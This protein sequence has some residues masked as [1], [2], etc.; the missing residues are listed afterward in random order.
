MASVLDVAD[1]GLREQKKQRTR[2]DLVAVA[3]ELFE[4]R[5]FDAVTVEEIAAAAMVS[6]RTFF[7]YFGSKEAVLFSDHDEML[8][9]LREAIRSQPADAPPLAVL[10]NAAHQ[11]ARYSADHRELQLRRARLAQSGA[12]VQAYHL[13][14]V[15]PAWEQVITE[16]LAGHLG[17]RAGADLRPRLFAGVAI[18]VLGA[19][20][21]TWALGANSD[22]VDALLEQ[23]FDALSDAI[24]R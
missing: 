24:D 14:V 21:E 9:V 6:S 1:L 4:E 16:E 7:R 8:D 15:R 12:A 2:D 19:V 23:A 22:D 3:I 5:G 20:T 18:A 10:R 13:G 11:L 17:V